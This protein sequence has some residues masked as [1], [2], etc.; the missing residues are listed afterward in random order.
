MECILKYQKQAFLFLTVF[1][2][3]VFPLNGQGQNICIRDATVKAA[4]GIYEKQGEFNNHPRYVMG[5][6]EIRYKGCRSKWFIYVDDKPC[7]KNLT[8]S[9][10]CPLFGWEPT[11]ITKKDVPDKEPFIKITLI[12]MNEENSREKLK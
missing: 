2:V 1:S 11:C 5:K 3:L 10:D 4:N 6:N 9:R 12:Q 8:D 7:Y